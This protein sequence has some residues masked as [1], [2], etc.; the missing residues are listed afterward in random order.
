[1]DELDAP[2]VVFLRWLQPDRLQHF[3]RKFLSVVGL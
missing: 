2:L 1:M 3:A